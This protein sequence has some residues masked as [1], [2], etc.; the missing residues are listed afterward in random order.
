M[1]Y[2]NL[3]QDVYFIYILHCKDG[4]YY[5]GLTN[6]LVRRF[7]EHSK[8]VYPSCYTFKKRPVNLVYFETCPFVE[9]AANRE[10][11]LKGW[12]RIKKKAL[13]ERNYHK[14]ALL[15]ECQNLSHRKYRDIK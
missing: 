3:I 10:K 13:I 5:V 15:A 8:G 7:E 2:K 4:S 1:I 6:D 11:Q 12:S 9:D 14:L